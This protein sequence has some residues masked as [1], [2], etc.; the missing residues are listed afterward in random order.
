MLCC[1]MFCYVMLCYAMLC[2]AVLCHVKYAVGKHFL[3]WFGVR[4]SICRA[5]N[6]SLSKP[7]I[8]LLW[9]EF[10]PFAHQPKV[11]DSSEKNTRFH[12]L[13][14]SRNSSVTELN[15]Y[16]L[17]MNVYVLTMNATRWL[18]VVQSVWL[19]WNRCELYHVVYK[20]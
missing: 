20:L 16:A 1:A 17:N 2:Y 13:S 15:V 8:R 19:I 4:R 9:T 6:T 10:S 12:K 11:I 18:L 3:Q 14:F 5:V 7:T